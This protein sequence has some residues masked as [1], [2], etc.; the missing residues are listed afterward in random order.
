[1][2]DAVIVRLTSLEK[3]NLGV[4]TL[5]RS[6]ILYVY[7]VNLRY[8]KKAEIFSKNLPP[9]QWIALLKRRVQKIEQNKPDHCDIYQ[10]NHNKNAI[11]W[12]W[13]HTSDL[14]GTLVKFH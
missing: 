8:Y 14:V 5:K 10:K 12:H 13:S 11:E 7:F 9:A 6:H 2:S 3:I 1:M 4:D